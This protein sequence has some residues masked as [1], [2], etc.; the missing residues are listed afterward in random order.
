MAE[1]ILVKDAMHPGV[2][3]CDSST[4]VNE[5]ARMMTTSQLRS[6]VVVDADCG[7]AGILS[8]TDLV[9]AKL[10]NA[11]SV[12]KGLTVGDIMTAR[13]LTISPNDTIEEAARIMIKH[14]IHRIV[15][16]EPD[17]LCHP[18]GILSMG[19]MMRFMMKD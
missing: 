4:T 3:S 14:H 13:V 6:L 9:N 1:Q 11:E 5:A 8:Q 10:L 2:V 15:V 16:A 19:D 17:D 7:L 18:I 12:D